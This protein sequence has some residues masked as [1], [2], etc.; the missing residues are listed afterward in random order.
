MAL[1]QPFD[2]SH[3]NILI[4]F[5]QLLAT[6]QM[7]TYLPPSAISMD[8]ILSDTYSPAETLVMDF[9]WGPDSHALSYSTADLAYTVL[10]TA[11]NT[12]DESTRCHGRVS[13]CRR[14]VGMAADGSDTELCTYG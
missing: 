3:T 6:L 7:Q 5:R 8:L 4:Q 2:S 12:K 11:H 14:C 13:G 9:G 10:T 1:L